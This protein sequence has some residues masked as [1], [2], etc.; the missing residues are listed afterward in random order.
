MLTTTR[1]T[2]TLKTRPPTPA[3]PYYRPLSD[4]EKALVDRVFGKLVKE[5][6]K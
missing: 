2:S 5:T 4:K 6:Q 3:R 1:P